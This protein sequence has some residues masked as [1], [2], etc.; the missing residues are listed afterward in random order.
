M[1]AI[2][3]FLYMPIFI[4]GKKI[5]RVVKKSTSVVISKK[6]SDCWKETVLPHYAKILMQ[7][8]LYLFLMLL[9]LLLLLILS[10]L[11]L[12]LFFSVQ[13]TII[14]VLSMSTS[15]LWMTVFGIFYL[16]IRNKFLCDKQYA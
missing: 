6:I 11:L 8:V 12:D 13:P 7:G 3:Y 4:H 15:W 16:Y 2:E 1:V 14:E 9:G 5:L 10:A